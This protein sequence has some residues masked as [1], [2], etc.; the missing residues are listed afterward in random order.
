MNNEVEEIIKDLITRVWNTEKEYYFN[1]GERNMREAELT[2]IYYELEEKISALD[3]K[4]LGEYEKDIEELEEELE[5]A[6]DQVDELT[7]KNCE[8]KEENEKLWDRIKEI[9]R[10]VND[11]WF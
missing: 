4:T 5:C 1:A 6:R 2:D 9:S 10:V 3:Q 11:T 8:L 7:D